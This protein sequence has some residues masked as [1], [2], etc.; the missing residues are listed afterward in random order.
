M[1]FCFAT[2]H[3]QHFSYLII[4]SVGDMNELKRLYSGIV[5]ATSN[6]ILPKVLCTTNEV[7]WIETIIDLLTKQVSYIDT[8]DYGSVINE[9]SC[10][11][12]LC[13]WHTSTHSILHYL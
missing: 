11:A 9:D 5:S 8:K 2:V 12:V 13:E 10:L 6:A 4:C 3:F 1:H 7:Q